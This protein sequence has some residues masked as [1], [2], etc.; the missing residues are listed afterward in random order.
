M[1]TPEPEK[2]TDNNEGAKLHS[3]LQTFLQ[4]MLEL[5]SVKG[6]KYFATYIRGKE[7]IIISVTNSPM[8]VSLCKGNSLSGSVGVTYHPL[9]LS[10]I[11]VIRKLE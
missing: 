4:E 3:K 10:T 2:P 7:E 9:H 8:I 5:G 11:S 1:A 6:F